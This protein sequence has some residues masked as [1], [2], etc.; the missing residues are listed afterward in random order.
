MGHPRG[1]N[2]RQPFSVLRGHGLHRCNRAI[3][4]MLS[5]SQMNSFTLDSNFWHD[6]AQFGALETNNTTLSPLGANQSC[7]TGY[8]SQ[9]GSSKSPPMDTTSQGHANMAAKN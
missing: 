6:P 5:S 3:D 1:A 7:D 4:P 9:E 2:I 8:V